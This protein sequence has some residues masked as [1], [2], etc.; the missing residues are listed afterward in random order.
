MIPCILT[1]AGS[2]GSG[3]AGIE[4]DTKIF[5]THRCYGAT[6]ITGLT[7]QNTRGVKDILPVPSE[8]V[9]KCLATVLEDVR[10]DAVKTGMLTSPETIEQ[11]A[12]QLGSL[13]SSSRVLLVVDPV[14]VS[15]S[16][17]DLIANAD[18]QKSAMLN[19]YHTH[20]FPLATVITP[21]IV[22]AEAFVSS[23][24]EWSPPD[25]RDFAYLCRLAA[26]Y[27]QECWG[28][29]PD[30]GGFV[31]VKGGH[32]PIARDSLPADY[33]PVWHKDP[34]QVVVD[35]LVGPDSS[36][37]RYFVNPYAQTGN[38]HGTG[39]NLSAL[40]ACGL[41][42]G[43]NID[44][45][46]RRAIYFLAAAIAS[47]YTEPIGHGHG[48]VNILLPV[49]SCVPSPFAPGTF[50]DYARAYTQ[51]AN[52]APCTKTRLSERST[53]IKIGDSMPPNC[54][55]SRYNQIQSCIHD[56]VL[57]GDEAKRDT[58]EELVCGIPPQMV[59]YFVGY[60]VFCCRKKSV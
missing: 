57:H 33:A 2:D 20:L 51:V 1:I 41:A 40:I 54:S 23:V 21:N 52:A 9:G 10:I 58:I 26:A 59:D 55:C 27:R 30:V 6:C 13:P 18:S 56:Y 32:A 34:P 15:T 46:V 4:T 24:R 53:P 48:P 35:I 31:L 45:A 28:T 39:C 25:N 19:A 12:L 7:A 50:L 14:M 49:G 3:G 11:V 43:Y 36:R 16:G 42:K 38:L 22:E 8:Y 47:P 37:P 17:H 5:T 44:D 29:D 60:Y